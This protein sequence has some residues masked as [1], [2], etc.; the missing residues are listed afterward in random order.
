VAKSV[1]GIRFEAR[2]VKRGSTW[3]VV[4][5][6]PDRS[7]ELVTDFPTEADARNWITN[8]SQGW[9]TRLGYGDA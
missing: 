1:A 5:S 6:F 4:V 7:P 2:P 8:D 9:L 3:M